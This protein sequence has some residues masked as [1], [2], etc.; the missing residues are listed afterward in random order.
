MNLEDDS[1]YEAQSNRPRGKT[2]AV[3]SGKGGSGKTMVAVALAQG[4]AKVDSKVVLVDTDFATG[5]L[6]YYLT[7][8]EFGHGRF[9][10]SEILNGRAPKSPLYEWAESG[11]ARDAEHQW[12]KNVRLVPIGDQR[13]VT[14]DVGEKYVNSLKFVIEE[15]AQSADFVIIDCRGGID[16]Q[17]LTV[18]SIVDEV[19]VVIETDATSVR[20]SQHLIDVMSEHGMK[21]KIVGFVMNKVMEDPTSLAKTASSLLG[22]KY[23]GSIPFDIEATRSYIQGKIASSDSL[24]T[25]HVFS[26][27]PRIFRE[28]D[29]YDGL[30]GLSPEEFG[31][32]TMRSPEVRIGGL[33]ILAMSLYVSFS[34]YIFSDLPQFREIKSYEYFNIAYLFIANMFLIFALSDPAKQRMG[35]IYSRINAIFVRIFFSP[36]RF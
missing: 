24:F 27:I 31:S 33:M 1:D 7:F 3:V 4:A 6:T 15:A 29:F 12:V 10:L 19:L 28:L 34:F 23:L 11:A 32:V 8:R 17:S 9:G 36:K 14:E 16:A 2:L 5:G 18:C 30:R 26:V 13:K 35:R 20:A 21:G 22:V 25:R